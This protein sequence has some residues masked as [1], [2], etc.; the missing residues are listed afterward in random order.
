LQIPEYLIATE[1]AVILRI[2]A[3][4]AIRKFEKLPGVIDLGSKETRR[5]RRYREL[6]IP[7]DV[8]EQ[9]IVNS[10]VQ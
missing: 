8:L 4:S 3:D 9:Y 5:K 1:V 6:R 7:R 2:S 10:R